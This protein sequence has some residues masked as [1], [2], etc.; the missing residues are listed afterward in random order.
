MDEPEGHYAKE[1]KP[2]IE[3]QILRIS[4]YTRYQK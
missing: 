3:R 4:I 1:N 2:V